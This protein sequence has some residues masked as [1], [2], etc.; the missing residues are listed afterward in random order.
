MEKGVV[1]FIDSHIII[2]T[3]I[4][5]YSHVSVFQKFIPNYLFFFLTYETSLVLF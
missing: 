1:A 4:L 2:L 5:M 3:N